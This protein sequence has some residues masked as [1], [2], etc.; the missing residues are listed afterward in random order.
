MRLRGRELARAPLAERREILTRMLPASERI[1]IS[2][3]MHTSASTMLSAVRAQ[4]LGGVAAKRK[5]SF[6]EAAEDADQSGTGVRH[7]RLHAGSARRAIYYR[8][9]VL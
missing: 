1:R 5:D 3:T 2:E 4:G 7:W 8:G 6:Y 9:R